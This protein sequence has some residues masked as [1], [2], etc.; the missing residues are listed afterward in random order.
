MGNWSLRGPVVLRNLFTGEK[1]TFESAEDF[2]ENVIRRNIEG[3][4]GDASHLTNRDCF[5]LWYGYPTYLLYD[6]C[7]LIIPVW[8]VQEIL[9][10]TRTQH[11]TWTERIHG[12]RNY[13]FRRGPVPFI[14]KS[15]GGPG[16][17]KNPGTYAEMRAANALEH[18]EDAMEHNIRPRRSVP[19]IPSM[20]DDRIRGDHRNRRNWKRNRKNQWKGS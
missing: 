5:G 3:R 16:W 10:Q 15:R 20:W 2:A 4:L 11:K 13:V 19:N 1:T 14:R 7:G 9:R 8:K 12:R 6:E 18:D 17:Y